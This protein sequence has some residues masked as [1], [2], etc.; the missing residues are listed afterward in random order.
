IADNFAVCLLLDFS[1][2][3]A[4]AFSRALTLLA[5]RSRLVAISTLLFLS[6]VTRFHGR[7]WGPEV[8][9][10][11]ELVGLAVDFS[12]DRH[13][14]CSRL[15][16]RRNRQDLRWLGRVVAVTVELFFSVN[17]TMRPFLCQVRWLIGEPGPVPARVIGRRRVHCLT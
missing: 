16:I 1:A 17:A 13:F 14:A 9:I 10:V 15:S 7:V 8:Q 11:R 4:F 6:D 5:W 3:F 2:G 12:R